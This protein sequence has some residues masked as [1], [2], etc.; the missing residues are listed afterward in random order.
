MTK[1]EKIVKYLADNGIDILKHERKNS[2]YAKPGTIVIGGYFSDRETFYAVL[3]LTGYDPATG[4]K[5]PIELKAPYEKD[6]WGN[7]NWFKHDHSEE[8]IVWIG[9]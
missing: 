5:R 6:A 4:K 8:R 7:V 3:D 9:D 1:R 2:R